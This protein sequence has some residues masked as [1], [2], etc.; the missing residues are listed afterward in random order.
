MTA[1]LLVSDSGEDTTLRVRVSGVLKMRLAAYLQ[2]QAKRGRTI[3]E[4]D[5][6]RDAIVEYL[7][8]YESAERNLLTD[9]RVADAVK[10]LLRAAE[11]EPPRGGKE[12]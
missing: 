2:R 9:E 1:Q 10:R 11:E 8:R 7:D 12:V 6:V 3:S 4:S 5:A